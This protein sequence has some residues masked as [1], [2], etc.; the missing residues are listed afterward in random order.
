MMATPIL[1]AAL[2]RKMPFPSLAP[3]WRNS[4]RVATAVSAGCIVG[5]KTYKS[6]STPQ[7]DLPKA[8]RSAMDIVE[9]S[10]T[11]YAARIP[12]KLDRRTARLVLGSSMSDSQR[13]L[14]QRYRHLLALNHPDRGGSLYLS[15]LISDAMNVLT[16]SSP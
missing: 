15:S 8:E 13:Q 5:Y 2:K 4:L 12:E 14:E 10:P 6:L 16:S 3:R 1:A 7:L 9:A 11:E